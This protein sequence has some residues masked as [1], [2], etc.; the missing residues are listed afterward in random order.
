MNLFYSDKHYRKCKG[1]IALV[2][3]RVIPSAP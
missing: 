1:N 3:L 2:N